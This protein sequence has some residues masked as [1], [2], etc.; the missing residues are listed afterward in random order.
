MFTILI[1]LHIVVGL[2][3]I[4]LI[5]LQQGA[6]ATAGVSFGGGSS[7]T[8]FGAR[9]SGS[10]LTRATTVL[11]IIFLANSL[12]LGRINSGRVNQTSIVDQLSDL[13]VQ[14]APAMPDLPSD[15]PAPDVPGTDVP[16]LP[17]ETSPQ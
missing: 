1:G 16:A 9:G 4:G 13:P 6:G 10:F 11:A 7:Q 8:V 3:L 5:L 15:L 14:E 12:V 17:G 2:L